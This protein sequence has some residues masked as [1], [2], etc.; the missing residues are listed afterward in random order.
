MKELTVSIG[1]AFDVAVAKLGIEG[2]TPY[3]WEAATGGHLVTGAVP[4]GT[5]KSGPRKGR[6]RFDH[7]NTTDR[8]TVV[9]SDEDV[10]T[11][12]ERYE[13]ETGNCWNCKGTGQVVSGWSAKAGTRYKACGRCGGT[14]VLKPASGDGA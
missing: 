3:R 4:F 12:A 5:Y 9:V 6:P 13:S 2:W 1:D 14:G 11:R 8:K 10:K 7:K